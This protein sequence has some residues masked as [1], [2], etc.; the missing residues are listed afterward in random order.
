MRGQDRDVNTHSGFRFHLRRAWTNDNE[1][2]AAHL[3]RHPSTSNRRSKLPYIR[4]TMPGVHPSPPFIWEEAQW[5][6]DLPF[7]LLGVLLGQAYALPYRMLDLMRK[8]VFYLSAF[9]ALGRLDGGLTGA[10]YGAAAQ[11]SYLLG[12]GETNCFRS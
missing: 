11:G 5:P 1:L 7:E 2:V 6:F 4:L 8:S 3:T 12:L 10:M 9:L